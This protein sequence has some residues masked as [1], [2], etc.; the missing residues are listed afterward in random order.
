MDTHAAKERATL[1]PYM[2]SPSKVCANLCVTSPD[3]R[4]KISPKG[5]RPLNA[6]Q[7]ELNRLLTRQAVREFLAEQVEPARYRPT[8]WGNMNDDRDGLK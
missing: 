5:Q 1:D 2:G 6:S 8:C 4:V 7:E 3:S